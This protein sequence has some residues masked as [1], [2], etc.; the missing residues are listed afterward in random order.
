MKRIFISAGEPSGDLRASELVREI[1]RLDSSVHFYGMGGPLMEAE[2]VHLI[3]RI[4]ES[5]VVGVQEAIAHIPS[6]LRDFRELYHRALQADAIILVDYPGYHLLLAGKL[7]NAGK[8]VF[9]YILPQIWA[10]GRFRAGLLRRM[11]GLYS[12]LPFER[13]FFRKLGMNVKYFGHPLVQLYGRH[14]DA[15]ERKGNPTIGFLPG[16]RRDEIRRL[17]PR[18]LRIKSILERRFPEAHFYMSLVDDT[19]FVREEENMDVV[20]GKA[21]EIMKASDVLV[22]ASGTASLEAGIL[23]KPA[24]VLYAMSEITWILA[25]MFARVRYVSLT[26]LILGEE[27][28]PEFVQHI[29]PVKVADSVE[30][31]LSRREEISSRLELLRNLLGGENPAGMV[32]TDLLNSL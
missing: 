15:M 8:D 9:Y 24:V 2:G 31:L 32:A 20:R 12:I 10:W 26:N 3:K 7:M 13:D 5:S 1:K 19:V 28:Y 21:L 25:N 27:V 22:V 29:N 18:M 14:I 6:L 30:D 4:G 16:S 17:V 23:G 11:K